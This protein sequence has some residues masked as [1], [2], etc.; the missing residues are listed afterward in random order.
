MT[1][2][3]VSDATEKSSLDV[4]AKDTSIA[5]KTLVA[6][7]KQGDVDVEKKDEHEEDE[8]QYPST[9]IVAIVM[10]ALYLAMYLVALVCCSHVKKTGWSLTT[11]VGQDHHLDSCPYHNRRVQFSGRCR[12]VRICVSAHGMQLATPVRTHLHPLPYQVRLFGRHR[13]LRS[14]FCN[15][16]SGT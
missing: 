1:E 14:W 9:K 11:A 10:L 6:A 2:A 15:L 12:L 3:K 5:D 4:V 8:T 13:Y 7:Q 16:R